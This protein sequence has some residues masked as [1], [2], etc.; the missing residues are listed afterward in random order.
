MKDG[1]DRA[2]RYWDGRYIIT[3]PDIDGLLSAALLCH[4]TNARLIGVYDTQNIILFDGHTRADAKLALW[5]D[6]D[7]THPQIISLGQ[8]LTLLNADDHSEIKCPVSFNP[9]EYYRIGHDKCFN[10]KAHK[11]IDK[12]PFATVHYLCGYL[13]A[14]VYNGIGRALLAHADGALTVSY[15]YAINCKHW[16][17]LFPNVEIVQTLAEHRYNDID[18]HRIM[19]DDLQRM[20]VPPST[21][22]I[23]KETKL[24]AEWHF[25][26]GTQVVKR[27]KI[28]KSVLSYITENLEWSLHQPD[29][30]TEIIKGNVIKL[31]PNSYG[32][33][34]EV[35]EAHGG[36]ISHAI[37]SHS[38]LRATQLDL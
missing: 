4:Y 15:D 18:L 3:S 13:N 20:G 1:I 8:H 10:G 19:V 38:L 26:I 29:A 30:I 35:Y 31:N 17:R 9:N 25:A 11:G 27:F 34:K 5:T 22:K 14:K 24:P 7:I 21:S 6:H 16:A 12:F 2:L 33:L 36:L 28:M 32:S 37:V 23:G